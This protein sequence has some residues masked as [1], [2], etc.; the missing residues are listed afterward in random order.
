MYLI[1]NEDCFFY[2]IVCIIS[3]S[4]VPLAVL[5]GH[6]QPIASISVSCNLGVVVSGSKREHMKLFFLNLQSPG[7]YPA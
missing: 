6:E 1:E 5:T 7:L 3:D 4:L 2:K